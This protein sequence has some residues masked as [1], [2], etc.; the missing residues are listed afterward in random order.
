M[1]PL[2]LPSVF[3]KVDQEEEQG[4]ED[5]GNCGRWRHEEPEEAVPAVVAAGSADG[6]DGEDD[7]A[8]DGHG[9]EPETCGVDLGWVRICEGVGSGA[10][11]EEEKEPEEKADARSEAG[12]GRALNGLVFEGRWRGGGGGRHFHDYELYRWCETREKGGETPPL[13]AI[14]SSNPVRVQRWLPIRSSDVV[15]VWKAIERSV[16]DWKVVGLLR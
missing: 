8:A 16:R 7:E 10:V 1:A 15:R 4:V 6:A 3:S 9:G 12:A 13:Q 2:F 11:G 14:E 5:Q